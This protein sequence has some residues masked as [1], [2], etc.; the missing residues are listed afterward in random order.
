MLFN[1]TDDPVQ[2]ASDYDYELEK[3][4]NEREREHSEKEVEDGIKDC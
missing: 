3:I 2:D 1:W 4:N